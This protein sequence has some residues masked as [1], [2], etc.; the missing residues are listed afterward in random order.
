MDQVPRK[1]LTIKEARQA[2]GGIGNATIYEEIDAG[3]LRTFC[4]GRRRLV[5]L[6]AIDDYIAQQERETSPQPGDLPP[7]P[8]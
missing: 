8:E 3:R 4:I 2:L 6:A 1:A 7:D 5:S